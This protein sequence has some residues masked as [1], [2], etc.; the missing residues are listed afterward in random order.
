LRYGRTRRHFWRRVRP[1]PFSFISPGNTAEAN[2]RKRAFLRTVRGD[3]VLRCGFSRDRGIRI[4]MVGV[5]WRFRFEALGRR[6]RIFQDGLP[7]LQG[8][9][10]DC[11]AVRRG[12]FPKQ[13]S[14]RGT[15]TERFLLVQRH[16]RLEIDL[17][18][19]TAGKSHNHPAKYPH[20]RNEKGRALDQTWKYA[21]EK[22]KAI[23]WR[24]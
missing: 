19:S 15:G 5:E 8:G 6:I 9:W 13:G 18:V 11:R 24:G 2:A 16:D 23:V 22:V 7:R 21:S 12:R 14:S 17:G 1:L 10:G 20:A 3:S 4:P